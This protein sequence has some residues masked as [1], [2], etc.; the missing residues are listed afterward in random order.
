MQRKDHHVD[1]GAGMADWPAQWR[2]Q[3]PAGAGPTSYEDR[4]EQQRKGR[5]KQP[6]AEVVEAREGHVRGADH[7]R[8]K[9]VAKAT[10]QCRHQG[11]EDHR[12]AVRGNDDVVSLMVSAE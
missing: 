8:N 11:E 3:C 1:G 5:Y 2:V 12:Q 6:K 7:Q 4:A 9:P 10:D